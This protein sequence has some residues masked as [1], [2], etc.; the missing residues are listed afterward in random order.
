M[1][2]KDSSRF[3]EAGAESVAVISTHGWFITQKAT[4]R[5]DFEAVASKMQGIDLLLTESRSHGTLPALSLWRDKG[6]PLINEDT[7]ALFTSNPRGD[8]ATLYEYH[9]NDI[10]KAVEL[11]LFL[12]GR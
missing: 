4:Q 11:C 5:T 6:E 7:A 8:A 3:S 12:M 9:I 2:G 10:E 1:K